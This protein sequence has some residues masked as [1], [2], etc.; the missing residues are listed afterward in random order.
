MGS[1][2]KQNGVD[3]KKPS[4]E[5]I[6]QECRPGTRTDYV[7]V[8]LL[9][10]DREDRVEFCLNNFLDKEVEALCKEESQKIDR[11]C[12]G[13]K[14]DIQGEINSMYCTM[15]NF[16]FAAGFVFGQTFDISDKKIIALLSELKKKMIDGGFMRYYPR[17]SSRD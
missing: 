17:G 7:E 12:K 14:G 16:A 5:I 3:S 8:M 2:E 4:K 11:F 6:E 10:E 13:S 1:K 15:M 9:F